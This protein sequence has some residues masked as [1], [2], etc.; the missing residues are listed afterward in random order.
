M[1]KF[2]GHWPSALADGFYLDQMGTQ[3]NS[4]LRIRVSDDVHF[5]LTLGFHKLIP[6]S[7]P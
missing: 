1:S 5:C 3:H 2:Q 6:F 7:Y 4:S